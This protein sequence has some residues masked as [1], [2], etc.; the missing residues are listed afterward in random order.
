[1]MKASVWAILPIALCMIPLCAES[2]D[3]PSIVTSEN[4]FKAASELAVKYDNNPQ[5]ATY[6]RSKFYPYLGPILNASVGECYKSIAS[7]SPEPFSMILTLKDSG[8]LKQIDLDKKTNMSKCVTA[9]MTKLAFPPP[10][11]SPFAEKINID[12]S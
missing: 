6:R 11:L 7:P 5:M 8:H 4:S 10:P 2:A 12:L 9:R 3:S 1:S